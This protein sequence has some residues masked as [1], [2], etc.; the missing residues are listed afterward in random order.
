MHYIVQLK[1]DRAAGLGF[2]ADEQEAIGDK[3]AEV[4]VR[5]WLQHAWADTLHDRMYKNKLQLSAEVKRTGALLAALM[6][7]GDRN[8]NRLAEDLDGLI[9]NYT[10]FATTED[11]RK[12]IAIQQLIRGNEVKDE[13][14]PGL[15]L[16]LALLVAA[17]GD[18]QQ[19]VDL[20]TPYAD[21]TDANR[22]ELLLEL[23]HSL[24]RLHREKPA[25]AEYLRGKRYLEQSVRLC[26]CDDLAFVPH[27]FARSSSPPIMIWTPLRRRRWPRFSTGITWRT[28]PGDCRPICGH[29]TGWSRPSRRPTSNRRITRWKSWR[30]PDSRCGKR[31]GIP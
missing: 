11:V 31:T 2:T 24:C 25:S 16:K 17:T 18:H 12:E 29:G 10:A 4:Q 27:P 26:A 6:E 28:A 13:K 19:V 7:E 8:F 23:G 30:P 14:K 3:R 22:C 15:A 9:A 21:A 20:L 5:T 1:P